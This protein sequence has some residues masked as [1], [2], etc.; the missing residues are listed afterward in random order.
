MS[1]LI[2]PTL[3]LFLYDLRYSLNATKEE[4]EKYR[5][6]FIAKLLRLTE[7]IQFTYPDIETEYLELFPKQKQYKFTA[8]AESKNLEGYYYPVCL[9]DTYGLQI[10]CS[11][12]NQTE[13]QSADCIDFL[14]AEIEGG[15]Q[16]QTATI[17]Q[18]W[19]LS[20]WLPEIP[21]T[22]SEKIA[23][24][25]Y[26]VLVKDGNWEHDLKGK[27][28]FLGSQIFEL[29]RYQPLGK[30]N[31]HVIIIIYPNREIAKKAAK[32]YFDWMRLF[33]YRHKILWSYT[34]SRLIKNSLINY[35]QEAEE[36]KRKVTKKNIQ[37]V[38]LQ[39]IEVRLAEIQNILVYFSIE[40][41]KLYF[42]KHIVSIN[43]LNYQRR[44]EIIQREA[45]RG[46]QLDFLKKFIQRAEDKYLIQITKDYENM[47]LGLR[48]LETNINAIRSQIEVEKSQRDKNFQNLVT[49]IG[50]GTA[51]TALMDFKG[52]ERCTT[53]VK[54]VRKYV[55]FKP[56]LCKNFW[57]NTMILPMGMIIIFGI[58]ALILKTLFFNN[59]FSKR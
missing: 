26:Q 31:L 19:M 27:G 53:I 42:Q 28:I 9:N 18:T 49:L 17:G 7:D 45:S 48:L 16:G 29:W 39:L 10:D 21:T 33:C 15:L 24:D 41:P 46:D 38:S 32:F 37:T 50:A 56:D 22:T 20:G 54:Q 14:K 43:L 13:P 34:Q 1:D 11:I 23:A 25:C 52:G 36:K 59:L 58:I 47:E 5:A 57:L 2:Y 6:K 40:L 44:L 35:F 12:D 3:D 55:P 30:D 51:V 4:K 8:S